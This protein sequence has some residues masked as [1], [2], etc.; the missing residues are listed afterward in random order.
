MLSMMDKDQVCAHVMENL[1]VKDGYY[2]VKRLVAW[3][4][5]TGDHTD[6]ACFQ[7]AI[8]KGKDNQY[9]D[10]HLLSTPIN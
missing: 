3:Y 6:R 5:A 1:S 2:I 10:R 9:N 8:E 4:L 7:E